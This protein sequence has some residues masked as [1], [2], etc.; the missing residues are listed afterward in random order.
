[1][2]SLAAGRSWLL[3]LLLLLAGCG[4]ERGTTFRDNCDT[5]L[6]YATR[7]CNPYLDSPGPN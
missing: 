1:M 3:L 4:A 7:Q 5:P 6:A 2:P